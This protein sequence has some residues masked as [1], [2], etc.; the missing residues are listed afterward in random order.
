MS[1]FFKKLTHEQAMALKAQG[2]R[3]VHKPTTVR[4]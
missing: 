1:N 2:K 3:I 4:K